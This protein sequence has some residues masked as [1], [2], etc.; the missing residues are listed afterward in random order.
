MLLKPMWLSYWC[1][2]CLL[3][4]VRRNLSYCGRNMKYFMTRDWDQEME[5]QIEAKRVYDNEVPLDGEASLENWTS[6]VVRELRHCK[7]ISGRMTV[8]KRNDEVTAPS[9][10]EKE[11]QPLLKGHDSPFRTVALPLFITHFLQNWRLFKG[12]NVGVGRP[13]FAEWIYECDKGQNGI[14]GKNLSPAFSKLLRKL[15]SNR[16]ISSDYKHR[17][18]HEATAGWGA[19]CPP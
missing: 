9:F 18:A 2:A 5:A 15:T 19:I 4:N 16:A 6:A 12:Y 17:A 3:V 1:T 14:E 8:R 13:T 7:N 10:E 11:W